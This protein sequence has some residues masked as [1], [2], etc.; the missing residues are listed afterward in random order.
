MLNH[1]MLQILWY[2]ALRAINISESYETLHP[3]QTKYLKHSDPFPIEA[4]PTRSTTHLL[5]AKFLVELRLL[6]ILAPLLAERGLQ[7]FV[8]ARL[9]VVHAPQRAFPHVLAV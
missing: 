1:F 3:F 4:F 9:E 5:L 8:L 2:W 7:I 6:V